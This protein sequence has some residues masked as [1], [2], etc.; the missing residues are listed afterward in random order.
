VAERSL[1]ILKGS[2]LHFLGLID[3]LLTKLPYLL[4]LAYELLAAIGHQL[5]DQIEPPS[6]IL[7]Q[8]PLKRPAVVGERRPRRAR[9]G[10]E[11]Y[12]AIRLVLMHHQ[13]RMSP[14]QFLNPGEDFRD[15]LLQLCRK[16]FWWFRRSPGHGSNRRISPDAGT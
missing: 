12:F 11:R 10:E 15:L 5:R 8:L 13:V 7:P 2:L 14:Q 3:H 9:E 6:G 1:H 4:R 16:S